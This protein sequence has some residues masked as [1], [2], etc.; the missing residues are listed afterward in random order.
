VALPGAEDTLCPSCGE[1]LVER[2]GFTVLRYR[3]R[4]GRCPR[5][6]R[7]IRMVGEFRGG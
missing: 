6:G 3:L 1:L 5:C 4:E 7:K 2:A